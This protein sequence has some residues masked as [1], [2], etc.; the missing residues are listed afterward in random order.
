MI[1]TESGRDRTRC[2]E[3]RGSTGVFTTPSSGNKESD[4]DVKIVWIVKTIKEIKN[5]TSCKREIKIMIKN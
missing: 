3:S 2:I 5:K 1:T 4:I